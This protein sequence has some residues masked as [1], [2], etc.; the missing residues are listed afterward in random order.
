MELSGPGG[1]VGRGGVLLM[2]WGASAVRHGR[3]Y[4]M[5]SDANPDT[6]DIYGYP[7]D[8]LYDYS[9]GSRNFR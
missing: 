5:P 9:D 2:A 3:G 8:L 1:L 7:I 4:P 6:A